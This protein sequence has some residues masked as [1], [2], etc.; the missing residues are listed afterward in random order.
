ML[1]LRCAGN[2]SLV[3]SYPSNARH[4]DKCCRGTPMQVQVFA[5]KQQ[6]GAEL[7]QQGQ[8]INGVIFDPFSEVQSNITHISSASHCDSLARHYYS[9]PCEA[10]INEMINVEYNVSYVYRALSAYFNRDNVALLG[11]A[12]YFKEGNDK[13][14][15]DAQRLIDFQNIRGGRVKLQSIVAPEMEFGNS[16]KGDALYAMELALSLQKLA[17][18]KL[19][20]LSKTA[21]HERDPQMQDFVD[22]TL[23]PDQVNLIKKVAE[24]V[25]QLRRVG[26][27]HGVYH[28]DLKLQG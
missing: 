16:E 7:V 28:F 18:E 24:Y 14:K 1:V 4:A 6:S 20:Y 21:E 17:Y 5:K 19:L 15:D 3:F 9:A 25:S 11:L 13:E 27:G 10:A 12:K 22:G 8:S 26:K 2:P 23:L